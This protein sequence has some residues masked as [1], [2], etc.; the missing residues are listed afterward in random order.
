MPGKIILWILTQFIVT[1]VAS[2][3]LIQTEGWLPILAAILL[4]LF[5]FVEN[6]IAMTLSALYLDAKKN[7]KL[8]EEAK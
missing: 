3:I 1:V 4:L 8:K 5:F 7:I 6:V 2:V